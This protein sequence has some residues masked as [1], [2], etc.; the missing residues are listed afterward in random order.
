MLRRWSEDNIGELPFHY[1]YRYA[2][3][4]GEAFAVARGLEQSR[5]FTQGCDDNVV[6]KDHKPLVK[7]LDDRTID[8][9]NNSREFRLK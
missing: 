3:I 8:E 7:I 1:P 4:E 2:P 5:Y 6:V 9:I